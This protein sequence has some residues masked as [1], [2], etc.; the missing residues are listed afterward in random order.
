MKLIKTAQRLVSE[1]ISTWLP[2]N[3]ANM[4]N[5]GG[6]DGAEV[7]PDKVSKNSLFHGLFGKKSTGLLLALSVAVPNGLANPVLP[8]EFTEDSLW[9]AESTG[10][11]NTVPPGEVPPNIPWVAR[12]AGP[13]D[14]IPPQG[15]HPDLVAASISGPTEA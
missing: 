6:D 12:S 10:P 7:P 2:A 9:V 3:G 14:S 8:Q 1:G 15:L 13:M 11:T 5:P 4:R